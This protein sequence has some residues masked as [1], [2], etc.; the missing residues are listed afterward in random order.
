[1]HSTY[2]SFPVHCSVRARKPSALELGGSR[3]SLLFSVQNFTR[4]CEWKQESL[5]CGDQDQAL[6]NLELPPSP[7]TCSMMLL[8]D[9]TL[10]GTFK[11]NDIYVE[12]LFGKG[13]YALLS[14]TPR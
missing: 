2:R 9:E 4:D 11:T 14:Q 8:E 10:F 3:A 1:M 13:T 6:V 5:S 12:S 7:R